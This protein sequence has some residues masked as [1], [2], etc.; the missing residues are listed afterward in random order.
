MRDSRAAAEGSAQPLPADGPAADILGSAAI[1]QGVLRPALR[2]GESFAF[3]MCNPPFFE[4]M[5]QA[6]L[7]PRTAHAAELCLNALHAAPPPHPPPIPLPSRTWILR[8]NFCGASRAA[9]LFSGCRTPLPQHLL[10]AI[11]CSVLILFQE[12]NLFYL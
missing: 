5:E 8:L 10:F 9:V 7:N 11:F 3:W 1:P 12:S 4:S 6:G 2:P